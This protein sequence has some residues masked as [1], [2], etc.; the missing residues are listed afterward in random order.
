VKPC[1]KPVRKPHFRKV[2]KLTQGTET[3]IRPSLDFS[4]IFGNAETIRKTGGA[5]NRTRTYPSD[6]AIQHACVNSCVNPP[7]NRAKYKWSVTV[8]QTGRI[9]SP[10]RTHA[11][12]MGPV[13]YPSFSHRNLRCQDG[14]MD[15]RRRPVLLHGSVPRPL[16]AGGH[17]LVW[18]TA[19][20]K[21]ADHSGR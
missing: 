11:V 16:R 1:V 12:R 15:T 6:K 17:R 7:R 18:R 19:I 13:P 14:N 5:R 21:D 4:C 9:V 20:L 10:I 3:T 2:S 8:F